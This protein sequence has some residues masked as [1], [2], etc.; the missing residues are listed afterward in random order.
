[1]KAYFSV[2]GALLFGLLQACSIAHP[3]AEAGD[4]TWTPMIKGDRQCRQAK[5]KDGTW[6]NQG[7]YMQWYP[8]GKLAIEGNF[9]AGKKDGVWMHYNEKGDKDAEKY[10]EEGV[11]KALAKLPSEK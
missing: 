6:V 8:N 11:E 10:F 2:F 1:M 4:V 7:K 3:C 9:K 5:Q